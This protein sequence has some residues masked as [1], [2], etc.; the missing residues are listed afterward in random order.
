MRPAFHLMLALAPLWL[1][2]APAALAQ[3]TS[4]PTIYVVRYIELMPAAKKQGPGLLKQLAEAS[5]KEAGALR[6]DV[7]QR[8][9]PANHFA[10]IEAWKDQPALDAHIGAAHTKQFLDAVQPLLIAPIDDRPCIATDA[11]PAPSAAGRARYVVTHVDVGPPN[12][13]KAIDLLKTAA[14]P[15]RKDTGNMAFDVVQQTARTNHFEVVEVWKNQK[16]LDAHELGPNNREFRAKLAPL[17]GA[18]YD[19]RLY[20]PL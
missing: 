3:S 12:R 5:R 10:V 1:A 17:L 7:L 14:G 9:A 2:T 13:E 19:Q 20:K 15:A 6:F 4:D 11:G 8:T 18:L 16:A